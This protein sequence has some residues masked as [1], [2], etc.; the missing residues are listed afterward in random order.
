MKQ[1]DGKHSKKLDPK[2]FQKVFCLVSCTLNTHFFSC[3]HNRK[4]AIFEHQ[5]NLIFS[6][7][8]MRHVSAYFFPSIFIYS[9]HKLMIYLHTVLYLKSFPP[10]LQADF[11]ILYNLQVFPSS[12]LLYTLLFLLSSLDILSDTL[13]NITTTIPPHHTSHTRHRPTDFL[14]NVRSQYHYG[15][16]DAAAGIPSCCCCT[17]A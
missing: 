2:L 7:T 16:V 12:S 8:L 5:T 1:A 3:P 14:Q 17:E 4:R 11:P 15:W 10:A 9:S 6:T 13:L